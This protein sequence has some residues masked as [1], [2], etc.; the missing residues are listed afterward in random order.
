MNNKPNSGKRRAQILDQLE[1]EGH[2]TTHSL[3]EIFN[4]SE[5]TI[6]N[7][8]LI[9]EKKGLLHRTRG[10]ALRHQRVTIDHDLREKSRK[11]LLE[12]QRIAKKAREFINNGDTIILDS[13]TTTQEIAKRFADV[14]GLTIVTNGINVAAEIARNRNVR[15]IMPGG[16]LRQNSLSLVGVLAENSLRNYNCD[17]LFLGVDGIDSSY[18]ISTPNLEEAQLNQV[19]IDIAKEVFIVTDSSKFL[20]RSFALIA[21]VSRITTLITDKNIPQNEYTA[22]LNLGVDMVLV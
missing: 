20:K 10:G 18:G 6:R 16:I 12:K 21:P 19:M 13:G 11:Y 9:F 1:N 7:D 14:S 22:L 3:S 2:V 8:L 5:V 4:V 15:L 17:K